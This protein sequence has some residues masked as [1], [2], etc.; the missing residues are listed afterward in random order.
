MK[1]PSS[2]QAVHPTTLFFII[3]LLLLFMHY[4]RHH[5]VAVCISHWPSGGDA[6]FHRYDFACQEEAA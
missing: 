3:D 6:S 5:G 4:S 1:S 2:Q